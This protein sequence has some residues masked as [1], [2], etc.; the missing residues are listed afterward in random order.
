MTALRYCGCV[1][2]GGDMA[3]GGLEAKGARDSQYFVEIQGDCCPCGLGYFIF[4]GQVEIVRA[5]EQAFEGTLVLGEDGGADAG[6]VVE[7]NAAEREVA[8]ILA[9]GDLDAA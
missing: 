2:A 9:G 1:P 5:V 7:V 3:V 8:E 4:D 6:D